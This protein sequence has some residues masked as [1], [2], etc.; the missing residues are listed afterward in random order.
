MLSLL[1]AQTQSASALAKQ[2]PVSRPAVLKHLAVLQDAGL[3]EREQ[4]GREVRFVAHSQPLADAA[5]WMS[6]IATTW[7]HRLAKLKRVAEGRR[8]HDPRFAPA[9]WQYPQ[10]DTPCSL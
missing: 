8:Q 1:A 7:E 4:A 5:E 3:I 2:L 6:V 9:P 10:R